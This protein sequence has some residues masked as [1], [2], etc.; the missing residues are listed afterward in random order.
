M[1]ACVRGTDCTDCGG[2][3]ELM[4]GDDDAA[5]STEP[6]GDWDDDEWFDDDSEEWWDDDYDFG[7]GAGFYLDATEKPWSARYRMYSY[8]TKELPALIAEHFPLDTAHQGIMGHSMGGHGALTIHLKNP[9]TYK[10]VSALSLI[11][12]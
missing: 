9:G 5:G 7:S 11:H 3:L 8:V 2:P 1:P 4:G 6:L 10:S 12:I